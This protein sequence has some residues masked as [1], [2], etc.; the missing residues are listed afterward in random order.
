M[1]GGVSNGRPD[2]LN[3]TKAI[4]R[5]LV[6]PDANHLPPLGSQGPTDGPVSCLVTTDLLGPKLSIG[7]GYRTTLAATVPEASVNKDRDATTRKDEIGTAGNI[8]SGT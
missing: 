2:R 4:P 3:G 8:R 7:L 1:V 5:K 6:L